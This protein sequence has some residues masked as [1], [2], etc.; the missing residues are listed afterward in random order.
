MRSIGIAAFGLLLSCA[1][2]IACSRSPTLPTPETTPAPSQ[3]PLA[4]TVS[5]ST[6]ESPLPS[7][8]PT[9]QPW[10]A[11]APS[12]VKDGVT[13]E[14]SAYGRESCVRVSVDVRGPL[15]SLGSLQFSGLGL[16][17]N[18]L[19]IDGDTGHLLHPQLTGRGGGGG[20]G[21]GTIG[22]GEE[23]TYEVTS[24]LPV[25]HL[26]AIVTFDRAL[27]I[28]APMR[29][30]LQVM[31]RETLPCPQLPPTTPEG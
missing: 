22:M 8:P 11:F 1:L 5:P 23:F 21:D 20:G 7:T 27:R 25:R 29:F 12:F 13:F 16:V 24:P 30:D 10:G 17:S 2:L 9:Q 6:Q 15:E 28:S 18:I 26:I 31:P 4:T 3:L 19:L 14:A